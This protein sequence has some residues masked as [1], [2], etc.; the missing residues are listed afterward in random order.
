M[1][2]RIHCNVCDATEPKPVNDVPQRWISIFPD[3]D[4]GRLPTVR[5]IAGVAEILAGDYCSVPCLSAAID[6][7]SS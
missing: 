2:R 6:G 7:F 3:D 1:S 5:I 4:D